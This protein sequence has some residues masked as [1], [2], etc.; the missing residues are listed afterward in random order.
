MREQVA[1][2]GD[3]CVCVV[4][5]RVGG[6]RGYAGV[7]VGPDPLGYDDGPDEGLDGHVAGP[8][9]ELQLAEVLVPH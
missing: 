1:R 5:G 8:G 9:F 3:A 4:R 6:G 2:V 7:D